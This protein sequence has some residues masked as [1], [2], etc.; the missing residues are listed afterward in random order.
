MAEERQQIAEIAL[1]ALLHKFPRLVERYSR[2]DVL[3]VRVALSAYFASGQ[4][5]SEQSGQAVLSAFSDLAGHNRKAYLPL[6]RL[7]PT[8]RDALFPTFE[9]PPDASS[10][11]QALRDEFENALLSQLADTMAADARLELAY[12]LLQEYAWCMPS[13]IQEGV[14]LFDHL[15]TTAAIAACLAADNHSIQWCKD[16]KQNNVE[17]CYLIG[18]DL[19]GLQAFIYTLASSGA[20]KSLRARSFYVQLISEALALAIL[21]ELKLPI[22]NLI[23]VGGGG[24]QLLAPAKADEQLR[25]IV[26]GLVDHLL[27][28]HQ[29]GLGLTVKWEPVTS[30]DFRKFN[31][32]QEKLGKKLNR[33]KRQPFAAASPDKL[34]LAIGQPLTEGGDPDK[35][36]RV[37]G[38]DGDNVRWDDKDGEYKSAFVISLEDLGKLLPKA[39]HVAFTRVEKAKPT[40][41]TDWRQAL[42]VF[43]LEAQIITQQAADPV[44]VPTGEFVRVWRLQSRPDREEGDWLKPLGAKRMVS[45]RPF[46]KLTP[47]NED[48][49]PLTFDE[50]SKPQ[51]GA[52]HRWGVLRLDVD[53]LGQL[54]QKGF[55]EQATLS[56]VASLSFALRL[57]F[58]GWL[59]GLAKADPVDSLA[60]DDLSDHLYIQY[61]GGDDVFVVGAWDA[62]PEFARRVRQSFGEYTAGNPKLTLS[63]GMTIV[64]AGFP[65]YQAA[66]QAGE[67]ED[68][69]KTK[70][71][72]GSEKDAFTLLG[73]TLSWGEFE[74]VKTLAYQLADGIDEKRLPRALPQTLLALHGQIRQAQSEARKR[75]KD[76]PQYGPWTWMAAYQLTRM[77]LQT[78]DDEAKKQI[79]G[80]QENFLT[81]KADRIEAIGL[82]ARWAQYL[83]RGG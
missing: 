36:C 69:A 34:Q 68:A 76:K 21:D 7:D 30:D 52:F 56:R 39:S 77:V 28:V 31:E 58:E 80:L 81:A 54:F 41:A 66:E 27:E 6:A 4:N 71:L 67:A 19:S 79:R 35:F 3:E 60:K 73:Q 14:S 48:G 74:K 38:D 29:G 43:G 63:G 37:T 13:N 22:T 16:A 70:R 49:Y 42:R 78:K 32:V 75:N 8:K 72:D 26:L 2:D 24:F 12:G 20:A 83:T 62:L 10:K 45:Y 53:N 33:A 5:P 50:L 59:P 40:R 23:Y 18:G 1:A 55:G 46:A 65:L 25:G 82:A 57:F 15:R 11:M 17:V 51:R 64:E 47:L 9:T 61:S 44:P